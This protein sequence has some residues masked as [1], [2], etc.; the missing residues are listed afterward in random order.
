SGTHPRGIAPRAAQTVA[1]HAAGGTVL[2][3]G[4]T[5]TAVAELVTAHRFQSPRGN[6]PAYGPLPRRRPESLSGTSIVV[7]GDDRS[8]PRP[9]GRSLPT[10]RVRHRRVGSWLYDHFAGARMR[11]FG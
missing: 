8:L 3:I 1:H 11:L 9:V 6:D 5:S 7:R 10:H 2:H 4:R